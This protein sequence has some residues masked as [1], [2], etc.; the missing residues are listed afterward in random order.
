MA[1]L[2]LR[3]SSWWRLLCTKSPRKR[4]QSRAASVAK[5]TLVL[6]LLALLVQKY[7]YWRSCGSLHHRRC[8]QPLEGRQVRFSLGSDMLHALVLLDHS[9]SLGLVSALTSLVLAE[10]G[11][12][13]RCSAGSV[14]EM[15]RIS[16][17]ITAASKL[18]SS[19]SSPT[20]QSEV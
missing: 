10:R 7:K 13:L 5:N 17:K 16:W 15:S 9:A 2:W 4:R 1:N 11:S 8:G 12:N 19:P 18:I 14:N 6:S 3:H 20:E